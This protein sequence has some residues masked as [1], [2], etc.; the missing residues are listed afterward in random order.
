MSKAKHEYEVLITYTEVHSVFVEAEDED[1]A[2]ELAL[3]MHSEGQTEMKYSR[4]EAV[5]NWSDEDN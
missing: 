1:A 3:D 2:K 4:T 5:V